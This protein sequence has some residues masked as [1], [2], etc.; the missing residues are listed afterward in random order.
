VDAA[1]GG[2]ARQ[3]VHPI[4]PFS[5]R[6]A[7][8]IRLPV[9][10]FSRELRGENNSEYVERS[11]D[12]ANRQQEDCKVNVVTLTSAEGSCWQHPETSQSFGATDARFFGRPQN[13]PSLATLQVSC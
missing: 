10:H 3:G 2:G 11:G 8:V 5:E 13:D 1:L 4:R 9:S 12:K 7:A 6:Q